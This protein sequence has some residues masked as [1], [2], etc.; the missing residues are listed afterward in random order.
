[1]H[2]GVTLSAE[3]LEI[4]GV[5]GAAVLDLDEVMNLKDDGGLQLLEVVAMSEAVPAEGAAGFR[6]E[7]DEVAVRLAARLAIV[8]G[9][10]DPSEPMFRAADGTMVLSVWPWR[11]G[12]EPVA[13]R[14]WNGIHG[15]ALFGLRFHGARDEETGEGGTGHDVGGLGVKPSDLFLGQIQGDELPLATGLGLRL[16]HGRL[17]S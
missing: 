14:A 15:S 13:D 11:E 17:R 3:Q 2:F 6:E 5:V 10:R 8:G 12:A 9:F 1:M 7:V 4:D 16:S